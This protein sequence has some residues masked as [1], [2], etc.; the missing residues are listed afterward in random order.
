M[1][2]S[3]MYDFEKKSLMFVLQTPFIQTV[4]GMKHRSP[5][6]HLLHRVRRIAAL[7]LKSLA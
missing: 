4:P 2:S 6:Y 3:Q 7:A 5:S 1:E